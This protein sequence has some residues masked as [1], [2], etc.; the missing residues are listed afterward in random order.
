MKRAA[1]G[2]LTGTEAGPFTAEV[3]ARYT[4]IAAYRQQFNGDIGPGE[5]VFTR[6]THEVSGSDERSARVLGARFEGLRA[7]DGSEPAVVVAG[8]GAPRQMN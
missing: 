3:S 8:P 7:W 6:F 1:Y 4:R 2:V 5:R